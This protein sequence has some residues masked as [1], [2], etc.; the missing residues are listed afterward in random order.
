MNQLTLTS[1]VQKIA[2][3]LSRMEKT[4]LSLNTLDPELFPQE[5]LDLCTQAALLSERI[6]CNLRNIVYATSCGGRV[7]YL[8]R[9]AAVQGVKIFFDAGILTVELPALLSKKQG[10]HSSQ[11]IMEPV[12]AALEAFIEANRIPKYR[13]CTICIQHIYD[14]QL[15]KTIYFDYD[16][17]QSKQLIDTIATHILTD[18]NATLCDLYQTAVASDRDCTR[19][20]I[21]PKDLFIGWLITQERPE[22]RC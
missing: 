21:M 14:D 7:A 10:R 19:I 22:F 6:T 11:I 13:E 5:Y 20:H 3:L 18:D 2:L 16:N 15:T 1:R 9:A 8:Q 4:V 17:K 12:S